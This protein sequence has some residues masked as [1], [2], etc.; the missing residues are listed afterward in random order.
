[1]TWVLSGTMIVVVLVADGTA[2]G[3]WKVSPTVLAAII[4]TAANIL[5]QLALSKGI[6]ISWWRRSIEEPTSVRDLHARWIVGQGFVDAVQEVVSRGPNI[7]AIA[8]IM[9]TIV[10]INS[11]LIQRALTPGH[12]T[13]EGRF[14]L[15]EIRMIQQLPRGYSGIWD[16]DTKS[17]GYP[18]ETFSDLTKRYFYYPGIILENRAAIGEDLVFCDGTCAGWLRG[19]GFSISC[20]AVS[21]TELP[22]LHDANG[23]YNQSTEVFSSAIRYSEYPDYTVTSPGSTANPVTQDIPRDFTYDSVW[24]AETG[25][26]SDTKSIRLV[27]QHCTLRPAIVDYPIIVINGTLSLDPNYGYQSD[28]TVSLETDQQ[29]RD[30]V[31]PNMP[32]NTTQG[33]STFGGIASLLVRRFSSRVSMRMENGRWKQ[34]AEG[35]L[36]FE[37]ARY[38][39][40]MLSGSC[41]PAFMD[42]APWVFQAVRELMFRASVEVPLDDYQRRRSQSSL[43]EDY[44]LPGQKQPLQGEHRGLSTIYIANHSYLYAAAAITFLTGLMITPLFYGFANLGRLVSLSPLEIAK[45]FDPPQLREAA[46]NSD[47][48]ALLG[49]LGNKQVNYGIVHRHTSRG[50][51]LL[52]FAD[53]ETVRKPK[54]GIE[55]PT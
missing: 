42:P 16:H 22:T 44:V 55:I 18:T 35:L 31:D 13:F 24:K 38:R 21:I 30:D 7:A 10:A 54:P 33:S 39:T 53:A 1:M 17:I 37:L 3:T 14:D 40:S 43:D 51:A 41:A 49:S 28:K 26:P 19:A 47:A 46:S 48:K 34:E 11:P 9:A 4:A 5:L 23:A 45:A 36:S 8:S 32:V 20:D 25:C 6:A 15:G 12:G 27:S 50:S 2:T 29:M 52:M